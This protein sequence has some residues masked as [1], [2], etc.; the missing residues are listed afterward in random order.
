MS[1]Q[2]QTT[3]AEFMFPSERRRLESFQGFK[4]AYS[5]RLGNAERKAVE[6][7]A[8][9]KKLER[10]TEALLQIAVSA[11]ETALA[12]QRQALGQRPDETIY[13]M[14]LAKGKNKQND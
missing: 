1:R 9:V 14:L 5:T 13:D 8:R 6:L 2:K 12:L 7:E 3:P 11:Q 10:D 4:T